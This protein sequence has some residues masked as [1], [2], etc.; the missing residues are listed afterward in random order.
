MS[1]KSHTGIILIEVHWPPSILLVQ[2]D[3]H[4]TPMRSLIVKGAVWRPRRFTQEAFLRR[5]VQLL[6]RHIWGESAPGQLLLLVQPLKRLLFQGLVETVPVQP[7]RDVG[8]AHLLAGPLLL[9]D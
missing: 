5:S 8:A 7:F 1:L 2:L 4:L 9:S 3:G 6:A